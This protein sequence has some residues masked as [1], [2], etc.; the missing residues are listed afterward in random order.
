MFSGCGENPQRFAQSIELPSRS[1][2]RLD[3]KSLAKEARTARKS[4]TKFDAKTRL[5]SPSPIGQEVPSPGG[6]VPE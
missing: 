1:Q 4:K 3:I 6:S 5:R 2:P